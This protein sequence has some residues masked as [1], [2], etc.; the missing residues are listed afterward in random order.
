MGPEEKTKLDKLDTKIRKYQKAKTKPV[1]V[2]REVVV[3]D[4]GES[5]NLAR[6]WHCQL[7]GEVDVEVDVVLELKW[8]LETRISRPPSPVHSTC[9]CVPPEF[10]AADSYSHCDSWL[11]LIWTAVP[12]ILQSPWMKWCGVLHNSTECY[13]SRRK[14]TALFSVLFLFWGHLPE[15]N[16]TTGE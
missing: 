7:A 16:V 8:A 6:I 13:A 9:L 12:R 3:V 11:R 2:S 10:P 14:Q 4:V 15:Q 1:R 5:L